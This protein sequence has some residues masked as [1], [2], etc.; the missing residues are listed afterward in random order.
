[1]IVGFFIVAN[2]DDQIR[3]SI[4]TGDSGLQFITIFSIIIAIILFGITEVL[5]GKEI[6]ALLGGISG[7]ILGRSSLSNPFKPKE[8]LKTLEVSIPTPAPKS[9]DS[10]TV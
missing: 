7:Y 8:E 5:G 3:K 9:K 4:F 10:T 6:S 2:R 1:V